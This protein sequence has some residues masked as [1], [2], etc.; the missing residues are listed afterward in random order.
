MNES[1][2][3]HPGARTCINSGYCCRVAPC[4]FGTWDAQRHQCTHL[5]EDNKCGVYDEILARPQEEWQLAPAF[6][7]GCCS[8]LNPDRQRMLAEA[9]MKKQIAK[10]KRCACC[11][12]LAHQVH[13][14]PSN[15]V[16]MLVCTDCYCKYEVNDGEPFMVWTNRCEEDYERFSRLFK[17]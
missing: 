9:H 4:P 11:H 7:A 12:R 16:T 15:G 17:S 2:P 6:G 3:L 13:E 8:P 14:A 1:L 5:T 10:L